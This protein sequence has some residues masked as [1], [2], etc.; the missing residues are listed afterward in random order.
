MKPEKR[1]KSEVQLLK[2][3]D[4]A[5]SETFG[6]TASLNKLNLAG[7]YEE[8]SPDGRVTVT[9]MYEVMLSKI[10]PTSK[11]AEASQ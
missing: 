8:E 9:Y 4:N 3:A 2:A 11:E 10:G 5:L 7:S 1:F 6:M